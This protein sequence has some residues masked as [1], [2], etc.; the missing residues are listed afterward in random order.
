M[1]TLKEYWPIVAFCLSTL[2]GVLILW[3]R[4]GQ[5]YQQLKDMK[6]NSGKIDK[7]VKAE[8]MS[9]KNENAIGD[10]RRLC[11]FRGEQLGRLESKV[12]M[13]ISAQQNMGVL[14]NSVSGKVDGLATA[15]INLAN[16]HGR[17]D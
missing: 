13:I 15:I 4:V 16:N 6:D 9:V 7:G 5:F 14:L 3:F 17:N 2:G 8:E 1:Q 12:E 11:G 10:I